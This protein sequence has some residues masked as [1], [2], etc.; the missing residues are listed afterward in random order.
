MHD[1]FT[2]YELGGEG[3]L[4]VEGTDFGHGGLAVGGV[5]VVRDGDVSDFGSGERSDGEGLGG[6]VLAGPENEDAGGILDG[7]GIVGEVGVD[8]LLGMRAV[9][10]KE[11]VFRGPALKLLCEGGGGAERG[12]DMGAGLVLEVDGEGGE[13]GLEVGGGGNMKFA[14]RGLGVSAKVIAQKWE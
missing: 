8:E 13:N 1:V 7:L 6:R 5:Q 3:L 11:E 10:G 4:E 9:G 12:N 2:G 14:R